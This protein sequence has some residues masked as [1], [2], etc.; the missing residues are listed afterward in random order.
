MPSLGV[1]DHLVDPEARDRAV[2]HFR[3]GGVVLPTL[4]ELADPARIPA[5]ITHALAQVGPD[6]PDPRN[7][8]RIHWYND[9]ARTARAAV[10]GHVVLPKE[11]TG[12]DARIV[13]VLGDRSR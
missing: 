4:G 9:A 7:L 8:F 13:V 5:S 2:A 12:V 10:P 3:A 11:L 6:D 1:E